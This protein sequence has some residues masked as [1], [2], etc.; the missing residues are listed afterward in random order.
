MTAKEPPEKTRFFRKPLFLA[1]ERRRPGYEYFELALTLK[2]CLDGISKVALELTKKGIKIL[3][4][5]HLS[6]DKFFWF[7]FIEAPKSVSIDDVSE[8]LLKVDSVLD[9]KWE[10]ISES[11]FF[12]KFLF[13][14]HF[15]GD[16]VIIFPA[17]VFNEIVKE[18]IELM[19]SAGE[20]ILYYRE[21]VTTGSKLYDMFPESL[22]SVEEKLTFMENMI[23]IFGWGTAR[24]SEIDL[25]SKSGVITV[26]ESLEASSPV[27]VKCN[28]LRGIITGVLRR[29]FNEPYIEVEETKCVSMGSPHCEFRFKLE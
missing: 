16:R 27:K 8:S 25:K 12:D 22:T 13:S 10:R 9:V 14:R 7:L 15:Y 24:L 18:I 26:Y 5:I 11:D 3:S 6:E 2:S 20:E 29:V 19:T 28:F 17:S 1:L 4:G 21:G 23:R